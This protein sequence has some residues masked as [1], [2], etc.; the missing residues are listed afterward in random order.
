MEAAEFIIFK[1]DKRV[2]CY[3]NS[4][5]Q[6]WYLD[7]DS[8][9]PQHRIDNAT[10][11]FGCQISEEKFFLLWSQK[12]VSVKFDWDLRNFSF[13]LSY[14]SVNYKLEVSYETILQI[15]LKRP[16]GQSMKF[17]VIQLYGS[18]LIY[19]RHIYWDRTI[20]FT[21]SSCIG[22]SSAM[23]LEL[24]G[25]G[26]VPKVLKDFFFYK[27]SP[28]KFSLQEGSTFSCN[29]DIVPILSPPQVIDLP[30]RIL[31]KINSLIQHG[32][33]PGP[34]L[35]V[36]FFR[37][38]S[39]IDIAFIE[40]A[41]EKLLNLREC[42]YDPVSWLKDQY[43]NYSKSKPVLGSPTV[44]LDDGLVYVH[45]VLVTPTKIYF[46]GPEVSL[47]N[48]VLRSYS[49]DID[50]FL[51][52]SFVDEDMGKLFSTV[53]SPRKS[54]E[55]RTGIYQRILSI[56]RYGIVIG[57]K[58]FETLAFSNS[59]VRE[60]TLW[61]FA[62]RPGLTAADIRESLGDFRKM[63]NVAE[64]AARLGQSLSASIQGSCAC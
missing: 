16:R 51:R 30:F 22:Q 39:G 6:A 2:I 63:K 26:H 3:E 33:I 60:N 23:C 50:N 19:E 52:V 35:D 21:P 1:A 7:R 36:K 48:R 57:D 5:L 12:N 59:Q 17:L 14:D 41:L 44:A 11:N 45:K 20:D 55:R 61:M 64:Y 49:D 54:E 42:C 27:E 58:K 8:N 13:L 47:S 38:V 40:H 9:L 62:S 29:S 46:Y 32:C 18:P 10:L 24:P 56:L 53:L 4:Y 15:E 43:R 31:F 34:A 25:R 28:G 37:F